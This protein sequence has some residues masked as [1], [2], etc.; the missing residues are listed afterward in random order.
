[1]PSIRHLVFFHFE[2]HTPV[3]TVQATLDAL[4]N[5]RN[6]KP[7]GCLYWRCRRTLPEGVVPSPIPNSQHRFQLALDSVFDSADAIAQYV[8]GDVHKQLVHDGHLTHVD[9]FT[10]IDYVLP[11]NFDLARFL[12]L[13]HAPHVHRATL[14]HPNEGVSRERQADI[15]RGW[16][17][18]EGEVDGLV[19]VSCG[20]TGRVEDGGELYVN[21][22]APEAYYT[23]VVD[24]VMSDHSALVV[25]PEHDMYKAQIPTITGMTDVRGGG[26]L[27]VDW[28]C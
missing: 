16:K 7:A 17:G 27:K 3:S 6:T 24:V 11:A 13:Q 12:A 25:F 9:R 19:Y 28:E 20:M 15:A 23:F 4:D 18:L 26:L 22:A 2:D 8:H 1:M 14:I 21:S 10:P 5:V